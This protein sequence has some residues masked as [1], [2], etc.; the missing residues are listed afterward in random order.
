MKKTKSWCSGPW[1]VLNTNGVVREGFTEEVSF[2]SHL[3]D[4]ELVFRKMSELISEMHKSIPGKK[5][6]AK[7]LRWDR[8]WLIWGTTG[9]RRWKVEGEEVGEFNQAHRTCMAYWESWLVFHS[10]CNFLNSLKYPWL[11][12]KK[13]CHEVSGGF[14]AAPWSATDE[15]KDYQDM[16]CLGRKGGQSLKGE[17][18]WSFFSMGFY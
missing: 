4:K 16:I 1:G 7:A 11:V 10:W 2:K 17:G 18:L 12:E 3:K 9:A 5:S 13:W 15:E 8:V 6:N 14:N